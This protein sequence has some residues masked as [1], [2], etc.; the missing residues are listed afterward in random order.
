MELIK[1]ASVKNKV[2]LPEQ[3]AEQITQSFENMV[4]SSYTNANMLKV[5]VAEIRTDI[6]N[7]MK[8]VI[9]CEAWLQGF[10]KKNELCEYLHD[11]NPSDLPG[12]YLCSRYNGCRKSD[13]R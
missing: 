1:P 6:E 3:D 7:S 4:V 2:E 9:I 10:C 8:K 13:C 11:E 12:C 5:Q